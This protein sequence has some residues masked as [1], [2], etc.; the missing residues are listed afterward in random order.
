M[1]IYLQ[2]VT[3]AVDTLC[4]YTK[5][6][7]YDQTLTTPKPSTSTTTNYPQSSC[8]EYTTRLGMAN[9]LHAKN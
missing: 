5:R 4:D 9:L 8:R 2:D 1:F 7:I 6:K 3:N